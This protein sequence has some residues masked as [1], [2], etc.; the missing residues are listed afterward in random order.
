[1]YEMIRTCCLSLVFAACLTVQADATDLS[2]VWSGSWNSFSTGH[3]G[4]LRCTMTKIDETSYHANFSGRFALIVPFR[5]SIT[6]YV[7]QD[8]EVVTLSGQ[9]YLGRRFGTFYY[10]A[11]A[12]SE[13]FTANY[14]SKKDCGQFLMSRCCS[15]ESKHTTDVKGK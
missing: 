8:G 7:E 1:M 9:H 15:F 11:E 10:T 3:H 6:L 5:Y 4:P 13:S 2:G 12:D 14:S